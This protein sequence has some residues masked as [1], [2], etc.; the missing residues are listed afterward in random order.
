MHPQALFKIGNSGVHLY[1][2][3]IG[4]GLVACILFFYYFTKKRNMPQNVQ[5]FSFFV[6]I[7]AIAIGFLFATLFQTFY[8]WID[9]GVWDFY[10]AGITVMGGLIGGSGAFIACYFIG[11]NLCFKGNLK[12][13]HLKHFK[14]IL[15]VAPLCILIAHAFGRIG[16]LMAGCCHGTYLGTEYVVGG[17]YMKGGKGWGY[18]V[19]TQLYESL[20]LFIAFGVLSFLFVKKRANYTMPAYLISYGVFRFIIEYVRD[21]YRGFEGIMSPSQWTSVVFLLIGIAYIVFMIV[22]KMPFVEKNIEGEELAPIEEEVLPPE[23]KQ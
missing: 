21:D 16:C 13:I 20:F 1:G 11:G 12:G 4:V 15:L 8:N 3:C 5:D 18:Y 14:T 9:T 6:A 17:I 22:T 2:L 7:A 10:S 19:P 23:I